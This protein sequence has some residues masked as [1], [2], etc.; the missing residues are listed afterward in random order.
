[1][2]FN[3]IAFSTGTRIYARELQRPDEAPR[4]KEWIC[5]LEAIGSTDIDLAL[6]EAMDMAERDRPT[7]VLFLTDGLP[8]EGVIDT[9]TILENVRAV[10]PKNVRICT[11]GVGYDVDTILLDQPAQIFRGAGPYVR[12]DERIDEAV[13]ALYAKLSAP[14]LTDLSLDLGDILVSDMVPSEPLPDLFAGSQL[15]IPGRYRDGGATTV[16]LRG[17]IDGQQ[18]TY[19]YDVRFPENAG[20]AVFVPRLWATRQIGAL[21][22]TI[23]L[24]G[25]DPELVDSIVLLS[26]R[27]GSI[28]P[29]TS[30]LITAVDIF[31]QRGA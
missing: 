19:R 3:V 15:I 8:T 30:C 21:L 23:S 5:G 20:G 25:E 7:V 18:Q 12:P 26:I 6:R 2:R 28:T 11:F 4:A 29:Y 31:S 17:T 22:N 27:Y 9:P 10:A 14:V 16:T 13:S 24:H 1:D